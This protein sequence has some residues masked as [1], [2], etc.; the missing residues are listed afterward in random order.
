MDKL[1]AEQPGNSGK[2]A[3]ADEKQAS[4]VLKGRG[5]VRGKSSQRRRWARKNGSSRACCWAT[6]LWILLSNM[7]GSPQVYSHL[8]EGAGECQVPR[9]F[10]KILDFLTGAAIME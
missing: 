9:R 5:Q 8:R 3:A 10:G 7:N 6:A 2:G 1:L 4:A